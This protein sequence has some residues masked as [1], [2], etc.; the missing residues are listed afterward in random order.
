M[1]SLKDR[2]AG[3]AVALFIF[4]VAFGPLLALLISLDEDGRKSA[5]AIGWAQVVGTTWALLVAGAATFYQVDQARKIAAE[6]DQ[7]KLRRR[8]SALCAILDDGYEQCKRLEPVFKDEDEPF[9]VLSF[10][11]MF[12]ARA[13]EDAISNIEKIPL[14]EI[15]S[16][17]AVRAITRFRNKMIAIKGQVLYAMDEQRNKDDA[18]DYQ[19]KHHVSGLIS[20]AESSYQS[21]VA[22]LGGTALMA[23]PPYCD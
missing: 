2:V 4:A 9:G 13:F 5:S 22:A 14:Y 8:G 20:E 16:H 11:L 1:K 17:D 12:D 18:D 6:T 10:I 23:I 21:A 19:I 3:W 15:E 7:A